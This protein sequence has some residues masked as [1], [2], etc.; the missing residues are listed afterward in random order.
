M[1]RD[2]IKY[3]KNDLTAENKRLTLKESQSIIDLSEVLLDSG[4]SKKEVIEHL[5]NIYNSLKSH[6]NA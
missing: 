1:I 5:D 3:I 6:F 2:I 4:L